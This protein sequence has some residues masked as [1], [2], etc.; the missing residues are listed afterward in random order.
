[1]PGT[2]KNAGRMYLIT[3]ES[4]VQWLVYTVSY[5]R[6]FGVPSHTQPVHYLCEQVHMW[7]WR[8]WFIAGRP[9]PSVSPVMVCH[10]CREPWKGARWPPPSRHWSAHAIPALPSPL[11]ALEIAIQRQGLRP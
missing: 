3:G 7:Q 9:Y 5:L 11:Q 2:F 6:R 8:A 1:M 4:G 10:T